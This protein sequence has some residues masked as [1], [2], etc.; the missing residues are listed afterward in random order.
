[1][2][3]LFPLVPMIISGVVI[4][5]R[6]LSSMREHEVFL[7][8]WEAYAA[9]RGLR[10]TP[11]KASLL[12]SQS[13]TLDGTFEGIAF[14]VDTAP[15]SQGRGAEH[16]T[17]VRA[18]AVDP[19]AC[20]VAVREA[21][22]LSGLGKLLGAQ[23]VATGDPE[24]DAKFVVK[25]DREDDARSL[26]DDETRR[27]LTRFPR[28]VRF[29]YLQGDVEVR[30]QGREHRHIVLDAACRIVAAACRWRRDPQIYR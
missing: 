28:G 15:T 20:T 21:T 19:I 1:M 14:E 29:E 3:S 10:F 9:R 25:T 30:W 4:A 6:V 7:G 2:D 12:S 13:A 27:A 11:P 18:R 26:L 16:F 8:A 24:F 17:R 22:A 23:A 5:V